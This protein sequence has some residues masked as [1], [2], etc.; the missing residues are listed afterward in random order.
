MNNYSHLDDDQKRILDS[1][2][3]LYLTKEEQ[4][5]FHF[6][7]QTRLRIKSPDFMESF[8]N[9]LLKTKFEHFKSQ[10]PDFES[11]DYTK[12]FIKL[13][14]F[15]FSDMNR[16]K[17]QRLINDPKNPPIV[18]KGMLNDTV[19]AQKWSHEYLRDH[20]KDVEI[21]AIEYSDSDPRSEKQFKRL[22][23]SDII[24]SQ[25]DQRAKKSYY[26]NNSAEIFNDYPYLIDEIGADKVLDLFKGHSVNSFSQ[27]FIGNLKTWGT[28]WHQ[29][30]DLSCALMINGV[31]RW[32][33]LDPK[34]I[35]I[36]K[37]ILNGPNGMGTKFD[38]RFD[39]DFHKIHDP[40]YAYAP[41]FIVDI[42]PGD[43]IFFTKYWAHAVTNMSPLQIMVNMRMTEVDLESMQKGNTAPNRLPLYDNILNSDPDFIKFKFEIF[44]NLGKK[45]KKVGDKSYFSG[46]STANNETSKIGSNK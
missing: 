42:E 6:M 37:P 25:L 14:K 9:E 45:T 38:V 23:L 43:V 1:K 36:L 16:E 41:K 35:Y 4:V 26:V 13:E 24:N 44:Q 8:E 12:S 40:L 5:N 7:M 29:G 27:L 21:V 33:F 28:N 10:C 19:S 32:I 22:Q 30:N 39:L 3:Y 11:I 31:K 2:K 34:L 15:D 17:F 46:I 20:Y 18:V